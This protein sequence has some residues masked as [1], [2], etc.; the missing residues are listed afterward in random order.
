MAARGRPRTFD[1]DA[2]LRKAMEV[3]WRRGY[4]GASVAMLTAELGITATSL[5]AAFGSKAELFDE[6][7]EL[8]DPPGGTPT[9]E[10][11]T[12]PKASDAIEAV[13]RAHA[14]AYTDP[15]TPPGCMVV[16]AAINLGS[17]HEEVDRK[18]TVR[19]HHDRETIEARIER[20]IS[21]GDLPAHLDAAA[22]ASYV[23]TV[24]HG[25]S[26]QVRDG[27]NRAQAHAVV[28]IAMTGWNA[29]VEGAARDL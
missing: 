27:F 13:L 8:Y 29:L 2:A 19:R 15:A 3:F 25:L 18:L 4:E 10:A 9:D 7:I 26:I 16:L 5:Y 14:D 28:D 11:L 21:E 12:R 24:L 6:A 23:Q 20:G 1:R 17:G 22:A